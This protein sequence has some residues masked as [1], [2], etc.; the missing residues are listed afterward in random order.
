[1]ANKHEARELGTKPAVWAWSEP[2]T[3][4]FYMGP[5][6]PDTNKQARLGLE[7]RYGGLTRHCPFNSK[8][9]KSAFFFLLKCA[10]RPA[11][12]N[13]PP[14]FSN[15]AWQIGPKT[16]RSSPARG[17]GGPLIE[18]NPKAMPSL[19]ARDEPARMSPY[20]PALHRFVHG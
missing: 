8:P 15:H 4:R 2:N 13:G 17:E 16:G 18:I 1:M 3:S 11:G 20:A 19:L 10:F 12:L 14:W 7:T 6:R 5:D 9:V